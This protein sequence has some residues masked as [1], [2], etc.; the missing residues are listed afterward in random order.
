MLLIGDCLE[1]IDK[2]DSQSVQTIITSP[3]YWGVRDYDNSNQLGQEDTPEEFIYLTKLNVSLRMMVLPG[4]IL[5]ILTLEQRVAI[6]IRMVCKQLMVKNIEY[7]EKHH[8]ST[9]T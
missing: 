9:D 2:I 6:G 5:A 4:L 1:Q 3:P 8:Q 7:K